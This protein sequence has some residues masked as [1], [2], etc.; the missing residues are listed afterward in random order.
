MNDKEIII[1]HELSGKGDT[2]LKLLEKVAKITEKKTGVKFKLEC[3]EVAWFVKKLD[4]MKTLEYAP[5]IV[6]IPSDMLLYRD[7]DFS[8]VDADFGE[9]KVSQEIWETM[10]YEGVQQGVPVIG[11]NHAVMYYNKKILK[12]KPESW[13]DIREIKKEN[14]IIPLSI[15]L[16]VSYWVMPF[17]SSV[18]SWPLVDGKE[19]LNSVGVIEGFKFLNNLYKEGV[20]SNLSGP[21]VMIEK[22]IGGEIGA[23]INGE[24]IYNYLNEKMGEDL[25]V[26]LIPDIKG[27]RVKTI[28]S[29]VGFAFPKNSLN[30]NKR[31]EIKEFI[32][33]MLSEE[34]Q[35]EWFEEVK[36]IPVN[37][38]YFQKIIDENKSE[39]LKNIL[40]QMERSVTI[41]FHEKME[42][43]WNS[44]DDGI[45][46]LLDGKIKEEDIAEKIENIA[47]EFNLKKLK[48]VISPLE[49]EEK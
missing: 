35:R 19:R 41:P 37:R 45:E 31:E 34:C 9:D 42:G 13:D 11:G 5:D 26:A 29:T 20:L 2:C 44:I 25:G 18:E 14:G 24:W 8:K 47:V 3:I 10:K 40:L 22:F 32:D 49:G 7:A 16:N 30:S 38:E 46:M 48:R 15:D 23:I 12:K 1:W 21:D 17:I 36:R 33:Y 43:I 6:F 39:N 27:K 4:V 28:T